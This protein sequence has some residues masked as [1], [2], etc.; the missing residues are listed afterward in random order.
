MRRAPASILAFS[1][2]AASGCVHRFP[3][4]AAPRE[5]QAFAGVALSFGAAEA[6]PLDW[7]FGDGTKAQGSLVHHTYWKP[8]RYT[9]AARLGDRSEKATFEVARRPT[10]S[11]WPEE[12]T[13]AI[14][15]PKLWEKG[16][17][18][19]DL[20]GRYFDVDHAE[21]IERGLAGF[22]GASVR[23]RDSL[24]ALGIAL[25]GGVTAFGLGDKSGAICTQV[26][27]PVHGALLGERV[28]QDRRDVAERVELRRGETR[29]F[30][31]KAGDAAYAVGEGMVCL[32]EGPG[33][34]AA[35]QLAIATSP[36]LRA[37]VRGARAAVSGDDAFAFIS[38]RGVD[39]R[40]KDMGSLPTRAFDRV[41]HGAGPLAIG[42][43]VR[44]TE[45]AADV[46]VALDAD[47]AAALGETFTPARAPSPISKLLPGTPGLWVG[48]SLKAEMIED[49]LSELSGRAAEGEGKALSTALAREM[50]GQ[51]TGNGAVGLYLDPSA[52]HRA[53]LGETVELGLTAA[54]ELKDPSQAEAALARA[55]ALASDSRL[56]IEKLPGMKAAWR[57]T[58]PDGRSGGLG[59]REGALLVAYARPTEAAFAGGGKPR[60]PPVPAPAAGVQQLRLDLATTIDAVLGASEIPGVDP[61]KAL[62]ARAVIQGYLEPFLPLRDLTGEVRRED[63]ALRG[64][65]L[66]RLRDPP[67]R[68]GSAE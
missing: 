60:G 3:V 59:I 28:H 52:L 50:R 38:R 56:K 44:D 54:L 63:A 10:I 45:V 32:A 15:V 62:F 14:A 64:H 9:V 47:G 36:E 34:L 11:M 13:W 37:D 7:D 27:D 67:G 4:A 19:L 57:T 40:Q 6:P 25:D 31:S 22:F 66:L 51:L 46:R 42:L 39:D 1:L 49:L 23:Q 21:M 35:V 24:G 20:V 61:M 65:F 43:A 48:I 18:W 55:I 16:P 2:L 8:G 58:L 26:D 53:I 30:S 68:T 12:A 41:R 29:L 5:R 33:S 17:H